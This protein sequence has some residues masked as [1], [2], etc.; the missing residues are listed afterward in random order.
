MPAEPR[1]TVAPPPGLDAALATV[2]DRWSLAVVAT[3]LDGPRRF[4]DLAAA[5]DGIAPNILTQRLRALVADGLVVGTP[6]SLRPLRLAYALTDDGLALRTVL[7]AL[8]DW[9][10]RRRGA[11]GSAHL[12][13][14]TPIEHVGWCPSC[15]EVV[16]AEGAADGEGLLHL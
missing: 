8:A 1:P 4:G 7:A 13:C 15:R 10:E 3:L 12:L 5:I 6:Y 11:A 14:G 9:A 2:G 16:G